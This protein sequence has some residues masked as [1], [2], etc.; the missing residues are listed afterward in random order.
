MKIIVFD[1]D[2]TLGYFA[3]ISKIFNLLLIFF[4]QNSISLNEKILLIH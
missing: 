1:L 3:E 4:K 2:E